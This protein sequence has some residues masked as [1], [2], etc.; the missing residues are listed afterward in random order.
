MLTSRD[1]S[2]ALVLL[3]VL[4]SCGCSSAA[5]AEP[6]FASSD[7]AA[8]DEFDQARTLYERGE[9][10][11]ARQRFSSF[12]VHHREDPLRPGAELHLGRIALRQGHYEDAI[13]WLERAAEADDEVLAATARRE[14]GQALIHAGDPQR[15][16]AVMEPLAGTL[17]GRDAALLYRTLA[18]AAEAAEEPERRLRYLDAY[19]RFGGPDDRE[20]LREEIGEIVEGLERE[21]LERL[22]RSLPRNGPGW[23]A[24][25]LRLGR[26]LAA[27]GEAERARALLEQLEEAGAGQP[28]EPLRTALEEAERVDWN[29]VGVLLP[30]SGRARLIGEQMLA[31]LELAA[32]SEA[33]EAGGE[34]GEPIRLVVRDAAAATEGGIAALVTE[35]VEQERVVAIIGPVDATRAEVAA[36]RA[37]E[38]GV[39]LLALSIRPDLPAGS[40]WVLRPFQS[41]EAEVRALVDYAMT[42]RGVRTFA[43]L[44]PD[45][46]YGRVLRQIAER[47]VASRG[48]QV[49]VA[50]SYTPSQT[51]FVE[52][53][54]ALAE[55]EFEA[56]I[57]P[58]RSRTVSLIAPALASVGLWSRGPSGGAPPEGRGV[59]L[60]L[61]SAAFNPGLAA[62]AGRYLQGALF[63]VPFWPED[64]DPT[65]VGFVEQYQVAQGSVPSAYASQAHD[66]LAILRAARRGARAQSRAGLLAA[67]EDL[68]RAPTVGRFE[69]FDERGEPRAPL[70]LLELE[71]ASFRRVE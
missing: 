26:Q 43:V 22:V 10:E 69:G 60:L 12:I 58:D 21:A 65:T 57:I 40:P 33:G 38:L 31:G 70:R 4:W 44:H 2:L 55:H 25:A 30:L 24:V 8:Q 14:L 64:P 36:E 66:A 19:F 48:G 47:E 56:L 54:R 7:P 5:Q 41:N 3:L 42:R 59:Q 37:G 18:Q 62:G 29:A 35:L 17:D 68:N 23:A 27:E 20:G 1:V 46:G 11:E 13:V 34:P 53:A 51:S 16:I 6:R 9:L 15:A 49:V 45:N 61:P 50:E 32:A 28:A 71:G 63:S 67:L 39:P 52:P